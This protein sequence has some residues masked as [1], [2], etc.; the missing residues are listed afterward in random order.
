MAVE[1]Q[2]AEEVA[3]DFYDVFETPKGTALVIGDV[4]ERCARSSPGGCDP[5]GSSLR[6]VAAIAIEP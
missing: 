4:S 5:W 3:G 1:Y 2:P 6:N